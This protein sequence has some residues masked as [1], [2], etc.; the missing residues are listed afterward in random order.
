MSCCV[1]SYS[2]LAFEVFLVVLVVRKAYVDRHLQ[3]HLG[4]VAIAAHAF[5]E[6][7]KA[8][9]LACDNEIA[10]TLHLPQLSLLGKDICQSIVENRLH[11]RPDVCR[12]NRERIKLNGLGLGVV[13]AGT[14]E[15]VADGTGGKAD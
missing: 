4:A 10:T 6:L 14:I 5:V 7:V 15:L 1:A 11:G 2:E 12:T 3:L 9:N 13:D 8:R